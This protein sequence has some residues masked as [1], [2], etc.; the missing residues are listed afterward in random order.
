[1]NDVVVHRW[2][3]GAV[4]LALAA[5]AFIQDPG[6]IVND[7]KID[8]V[9]DPGSFLARAM[10]LWD[11]NGT[12]GQVQNQAYGYLFPMGPFFWLG[13]LIDL[14]GWVV[15]RAWWSL[16]LVVAFLGI[17]KLC[18][19][20]DLGSP[21][22]RILGGLAF[23]L[24]PRMLTVIGPSSIEVWPAAVAPWVLV[25]LVLGLR[26]RD[27]RRMA[28]LS[29]LLVAAI[30]GVN[31]AATAAVLPLGALLVLLA[32]PGPRRRSL[33]IWWPLATVLTTAWW[34]VPLVLL[35]KYSP[36][37]LDFI[38]SSSTTTFAAT[39]FD[40]LRGTTNWLPYLDSSQSAGFSL[41]SDSVL[42]M[43]S[44]IVLALG[45]WGLGRRD[46]PWRT[47]LLA[48]AVTGL[49]LVT[50][51]H[52]GTG[53]W[54]ASGWQSLLDGVLAPLRNT[55]KFDVVIRIPLVLGLVHAITVLTSSPRGDG[56]NRRVRGPVV[57]AA[58][59][60]VGAA[61]PAWTADLARDGSF[62]AT[63][64][65]WIE[66]VDWL[67]ANAEAQ[68]TLM[69]PGSS[70]GDYLWGR[71]RDEVI[72]ALG[73]TPWSV[74][75]AVPLT[76][77][78]AIRTLDAFE[79]A[80]ATGRGSRSLTALL[81]RSGIR[82]LLVRSD[83]AAP[84]ATDPELVFSTLSSTPGVS[85][86]ASFGP[87]V[88]SPATQPAGDQIVYVNGGLQSKHPAIE[89]FEVED[90]DAAVMRSGDPDEVPALAG[91]PAGV[92]VAGGL[93]DADTDFL[94]AQDVPGGLVP[95]RTVLTDTDRRQEVAFGRVPN[96]RSATLTRDDPYRIDRPVHDYL[97]DGQ[98][99]WKTVATLLGAE[100]ITASSSVS[101]VTES[102]IDPSGHPW[103]AFDDDSTTAWRAG[104]LDGW[105][106]IAYGRAVDLTG[107]TIRLPTAAGTRTVSIKTDE[108]TTKVRAVGGLSV[109]L[110]VDASTETLRIGLPDPSLEALSIAEVTVPDAPV[111]R[112][113][114]L[115]T[116]PRSW[117][118][119]TDVLL[120]AAEGP[121][122]CRRVEGVTRCAA[123]IDGRGEDGSTID[124]IVTL[125]APARYA[126]GLSVRP[127]QSGALVD[128]LS[129]DLG[130]R[131]T[132]NASTD[133]AAG[134]LA[135]I[136]GDAETGWVASLGDRTP[137]VTLDL[138]QVT[139]LD[140]LVLRT[141]VSLAASAPSR[142]TLTFDDGSTQE[143]VVDAR[144]RL[145]FDEVR[146]RSVTISI[147][148]A[149]VRSTLA[150]DGSGS[151]LPVGISEISVPG[152]DIDPSD[153]A[154]T[155]VEL[156]C[157]TGPTVQVGERRFDSAVSA[158]RRAVTAG[159]D[160][161][162][163][164]CGG[165]DTALEF[166]GNRIVVDASTAFRPVALRL[167]QGSVTAGQ[168]TSTPL[169]RSGDTAFTAEPPAGGSERLVSVPQTVNPG[170][171]AGEATPVTV[172]GWM[173]GWLTDADQVDASFAPTTLYRGGLV[174]GAL[175]VLL[176]AV[177]A[178][179]LPPIE[180]DRP[181]RDQRTGVRTTLLGLG[182]LV[183]AATIAG[184]AG[185]VAVVSGVLVVRFAG[186][187]RS[188]LLVGALVVAAG[189]AYVVRPWTDTSG[190]AGELDW[191]QWLVLGALGVAAG[192]GG[193][194]GGLRSPRLRNFI[195][196]RSTTA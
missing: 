138:S 169:D 171:K 57:L 105:I 192:V 27:P 151:G 73:S 145:S 12:F 182:L 75:N 119:P 1:M 172:N 103:A 186:P 110:G 150:F 91:S 58:V 159:A 97:S 60:L 43:N 20:L 108:G 109:P 7:T 6:R 90:A 86:I 135:M 126:A 190:W 14:P 146:S 175:L 45:L 128:L 154:E 134:P 160:L 50:L 48:G 51:G 104:D 30:G 98:A 168:T 83:L 177:A 117:G 13:D 179:R 5:L 74:R 24:S 66:A 49:V 37:F 152:T 178:R 165:E 137:A 62:E 38:E 129:P 148:R 71:P 80:F 15:Q 163:R 29:A 195:A 174:I 65:Y 100:S 61:V 33:M 55:H 93:F 181:G 94:L 155:I 31:A 143:A 19:V 40:A 124:R 131:V 193:S 41:I 53:G 196:G 136:D 46:Q 106:E 156:P 22:A 78:G 166:G 189:L 88:G 81:Q 26:S 140:R 92:L 180:V 167:T 125:E 67:D 18:S 142:V 47:W 120:T 194:A 123:G 153:G 164:V 144:G 184:T 147:D 127:V 149:Y 183:G 115:P 96:G 64:G 95:G 191:P 42:I 63:P 35:G 99:R 87:D 82:Y 112:P 21:T 56:Q 176:V 84:G 77:P 118:N 133:P 52:V 114:T 32:S 173:Q 39:A 9:L 101:D 157:G 161:S 187:R 68:N 16:L 8:L 188:E 122:T 79:Q 85:S 170:W 116:V 89:I 28:L 72:Q 69:L 111:A 11:P 141:D 17:V 132:S 25:P 2:R 44:L 54:G 76:P 3:L 113:L 107:A 121:A 162:A 102:V 158:S 130:L 23:A 59:A 139:T 36:P 34:T 10:S 4:S 185:L 70:F